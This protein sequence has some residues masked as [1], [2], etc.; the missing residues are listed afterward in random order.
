MCLGGPDVEIT[1]CAD[2]LSGL[3]KALNS[4]SDLLI[5]DIALPG[6]DGWKVLE[7][8]RSTPDRADLPVIIV[9]AHH[10]TVVTEQSLLAQTVDGFLGKPFDIGDLTDAVERIIDDTTPTESL[11]ATT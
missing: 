8:I 4:K 1:S 5:L 6:L 3:D 10:D 11:G 2:G 9:T 7:R